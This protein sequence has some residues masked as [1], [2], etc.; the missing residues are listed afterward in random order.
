MDIASTTTRFDEILAAARS[1]DKN[2]Q[3]ATMTVVS[4]IQQMILLMMKKGLMFYCEQDNF[5]ARNKF[6]EKVMELK[7][8]RT[9]VCRFLMRICCKGSFL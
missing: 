5:K 4:H 9:S 3:S 6:L 1:Q 2:Q 8:K 7:A